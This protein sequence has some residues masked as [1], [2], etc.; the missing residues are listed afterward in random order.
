MSKIL[1]VLPLALTMNLGPQAVAAITLITTKNPVKKYLCYLA[2]I[3]LAATSI[4]CI[5]FFVFG[6]L[7]TTTRIGGKT[8]T[9][10][11]ADYVF[12]GLL[13]ILA[14]RIFLKRKKIE[15]PKWLSTIQDADAKRVFVIGL[16][17]YS[18]M[19]TDLVSMLTVGQYLA[20]HKMHFY[21][22]FPFLAL[23]LLIAALPILSYLVF[24]K[25]AEAAMPGVR[26]WL[27]VHAWIINEVVIVFFIFMI[28]FT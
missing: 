16:M 13:A 12:A 8:K 5:A 19:P 11:I 20:V 2:A 14:V 15:K 23:T 26:D 3:L 21:S 1:A 18:F 27:D 25:R 4:T 28:I 24:K 9:G 7:D 10:H 17:L 6:L 22:A